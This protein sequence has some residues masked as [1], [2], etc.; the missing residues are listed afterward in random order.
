VCHS[1]NLH[2]KQS[3]RFD[4]TLAKAQRQLYELQAAWAFAT[5]GRRRTR[6]KPRSPAS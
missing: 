5:P 3:Q 2:A 1:E 6:S 4:E